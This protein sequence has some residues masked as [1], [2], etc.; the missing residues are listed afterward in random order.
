MFTFAAM[1]ACVISEELQFVNATLQ[2]LDTEIQH[3]ETLRTKFRR[4]L[5]ELE[6][7]TSVLPP[8]TLSTIF[9]A[10]C[11]FPEDLACSDPHS[12][13]VLASVCS[14]WQRVVHSTPSL[15][16]G[17]VLR[18]HG[19]NYTSKATL[20][21]LQLYVQRLRALPLSLRI[22]FD[23]PDATKRRHLSRAKV[24]PVLEL[25]KLILREY[26]ERLGLLVLDQIPREWWSLLSST[27]SPSIPF[28]RLKRLALSWSEKPRD[29]IVKPFRNDMVPRLERISL[30]GQR[31]PLELPWNQITFLELK[32]MNV[33]QCIGLLLHCPRLMEYRC[34]SAFLPAA[35]GELGA[36]H[37]VEVFPYMES[38]CW[39]FGL[40]DWDMVLMTHAHFPTLRRMAWRR[41]AYSNSFLGDLQGPSYRSLRSQFMSRLQT[42]TVFECSLSLWTIE[43]LCNSLPGSLR[44]LYLTEGHD[45]VVL[46]SFRALTLHNGRP[47]SNRF[48]HLQILG[49]PYLYVS[50][51][52]RYNLA[53]A[54]LEMLQSRREGP[55]A[56]WKQY[57]R[58]QRVY[59]MR[60]SI[61]LQY[62]GWNAI[63]YMEL[64]RLV[65][66][67]LELVERSEQTEAWN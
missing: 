22:T 44:E 43:D 58:L 36:M 17:L 34:Q 25:F 20:T 65:R 45:T 50:Y 35:H 31:L 28:P 13:L 32:N 2:R 8:E 18:L 3:L 54:A 12:P 9:E 26:P 27:V 7:H 24:V 48:P 52:D 49:M 39:D 21:L 56:K 61:P 10:V 14:H 11:E 40:A 4:R 33:G 53:A 57:T 46:D 38:M 1:D 37:Q 64:Q 47:S 23:Q 6:A 60:S 51:T 42:L 41:H 66:E 29:P 19:Q 67:G 55:P 16:Q 15:W 63:Q 62:A 59:F 5:N 30:S